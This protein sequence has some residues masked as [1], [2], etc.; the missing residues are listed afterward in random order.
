MT[1]N[2]S[3]NE[4]ECNQCSWADLD[5]Y[6]YA[7]MIEQ[8]STQINKLSKIMLGNGDAEKGMISRVAKAETKLDKL[9][10]K[11]AVRQG[12]VYSVI[13]GVLVGV[14]LLGFKLIIEVI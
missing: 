1:K 5:A 6:K 12:L 11:D 2:M 7:S 3:K 14:T 13:G 8:T 9:D 4:E 10:G